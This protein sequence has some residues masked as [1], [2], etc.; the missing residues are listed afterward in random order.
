MC[1]DGHICKLFVY[2]KYYAILSMLFSPA[3]VSGAKGVSV[4]IKCLKFID[5]PRDYQLLN[6][7]FTTTCYLICTK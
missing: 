6:M 5:Q 2:Y 4:E 1:P 3:F 7:H